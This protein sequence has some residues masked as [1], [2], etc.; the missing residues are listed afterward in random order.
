MINTA[1][2]AVLPVWRTVPN[3]TLCRDA[4]LPTAGLALK[5]VRLR[6]ALR[7]KT[8]DEKHPLAVGTQV[9]LISTG[10]KR[11]TPHRLRTRLQVSANALD[12]VARPTL[13]GPRYTLGSRINPTGG[14]DKNKAAKAFMQWFKAQGPGDLT[15][16]SDGSKG[17]DGIGYGYVVYRGWE[18]EPVCSGRASLDGKSVVYDAE[19]IGAC[20]GLQ[21]ACAVAEPDDEITVCLDNTA[22]IWGLRG[23]AALSSRWAFQAFHELADQR[24]N[25]VQVRW[26]P[27]H[28]GIDGNEL[29]DK[30]AKEGQ[31]A[32]PDPDAGPTIA[33]IRAQARR[34]LRAQ[35]EVQWNQVQDGLS[36]RYKSWHLDYNLRCPEELGLPRPMLQKY[37]AI[38]TGHGDFAWYHRKFK[39]DDAEL[40]CSAC[41][42]AKTPEHIVFCRKTTGRRTFDEWPWP[43]DRE[44]RYPDT[45]TEKH[46]YLADLIETPTAFKDFLGATGTL[47]LQGEGD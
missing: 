40:D 19:V 6:F 10:S 5:E 42:R 1:I 44:R 32:D 9:P 38:R 13:A 8:V 36:S 29:A 11:G 18:A 24:R 15:V 20:R 45:P 46:R 47:T 39:H 16:F 28:K 12:A 43:G 37:L 3:R 2:R 22:A 41:R 26:C 27:G 14:L 35:K 34:L 33:G 17:E 25:G 4:G 23:Q 31:K 21:A 7:L 30:L